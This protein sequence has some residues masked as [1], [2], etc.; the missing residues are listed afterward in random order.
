MKANIEERE[1]DIKE[2]LEN[3]QI[4][5]LR[6][7]DDYLN[8]IFIDLAGK[9]QKNIK[10][11]EKYLFSKYFEIY[12][13]VLDRLFKIFDLGNDGVLD[14]AEFVFGMKILYSQGTSF[15][16]LTKFIFKLYDFDQNGKISKDDV[17]LI[18]SHIF[19]STNDKK[20]K[21][22]FENINQFQSKI[23]KIIDFSFQE[24]NEID[25]NDFLNIIENK[26][27]DI[28]IFLLMFLLE[29]RPFS[30][31]TFFVYI[32]EKN[33]SLNLIELLE[34]YPTLDSKI[35]KSPIVN[36]KSILNF[37]NKKYFNFNKLLQANNKLFDLNTVY[38]KIKE[39]IIFHEGL[40][41]KISEDE[42]N[43]IKK[44][45]KIFFRLIG[46]D[47]Y[48]YKKS[49]LTNHKGINNLSCSFV[50][51]GEDFVVNDVK[52]FSIII[53][54]YKKEKIY[55]FDLKENRDIWLEKF[56]E[57]IGQKNIKNKYKI[58]KKIIGTGALCS[59]KYG[60][61][62]ETKQNVA[63]KIIKKKNLDNSQLE[64]VMNE[65]YIM[66]ICKYSYIIKLYDIYENNDRIYIVME[67]CKNGNLLNY[68]DDGYYELQENLAKEIIFKLLSVINFIHSLGIIHKDIKLDNILFF[69]E[70]KVNIRLI[71][72]GFSKILGPNEKSTN[73]C[74]TLTFAAPEL[75]LDRPYSKSVDIWSIGIVTFFL[76]CGYLPFDDKNSE[77]VI[78]QIVEDPTP[79]KESVWK[80]I[81]VEAK[82]FVAGLL[83]KNPKKRLN[84]E[85]GLEHPWLK[86]LY[87]A[88]EITK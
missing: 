45:K 71:D 3:Y 14:R 87:K 8:E 34:K 20:L 25:F 11:I 50:K 10:T 82:D 40:I 62:L 66:Q 38:L 56:R 43:K 46:K 26:S 54:Y 86:S 75:L 88:K 57:V 53:N 44:I 52:Y 17:K 30:D 15:K 61:N 55:Y 39:S 85:Q 13:I 67:H 63:I 9:S 51:E 47:L 31:E 5:E 68:F 65:L 83:E 59:V 37:H 29:K 12:G 81:S 7:F 79:F 41:F 69:D 60:T 78:R 73:R 64:S 28:F 2:I 22:N 4:P 36:I 72:F 80:Y 70:T 6:F 58:S 33:I 48:Y 18:L 35:I 42:N 32:S 76:L 16:S 49:D 1:F 23:K 77:E 24:K 84:I 74:G 19:L 21:D 27:S